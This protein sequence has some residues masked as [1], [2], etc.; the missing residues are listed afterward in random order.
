[1]D[2]TFPMNISILNRSIEE[3]DE[4]VEVLTVEI[5]KDVTLYGEIL[6]SHFSLQLVHTTLN[7]VTSQDEEF[8]S[9][10]TDDS[11]KIGP[12][13]L[14]MP[15]R[16]LPEFVHLHFKPDCFW[17]KRLLL[18]AQALEKACQNN[19]EETAERKSK[20]LNTSKTL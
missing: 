19:M 13:N 1:M 18:L 6:F 2:G 4:V 16:R 14:L 10:V 15:F 8:H 12:A 17:A 5:S 9:K 20:R 11:L 3:I 7:M